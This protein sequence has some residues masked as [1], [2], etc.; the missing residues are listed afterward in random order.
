VIVEE[1]RKTNDRTDQKCIVK[2]EFI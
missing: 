2:I 1:K